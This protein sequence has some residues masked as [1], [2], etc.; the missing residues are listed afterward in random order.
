MSFETEQPFP[1]PSAGST[2]HK[3]RQP[4][5]DYKIGKSDDLTEELAS[6]GSLKHPAVNPSELMASERSATNS[7][8]GKLRPSRK[9]PATNRTESRTA[10]PKKHKAK[11][12]TVA[13]YYWVTSGKGWALKGSKRD[14]NGN[15]PYLGYLSAE[16]YHEMKSQFKGD[17]LKAVLRQWIEE[18]VAAKNSN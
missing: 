9:R 11:P 5:A 3:N 16:R 8:N 1:A 17:D 12:L 15:N 4:I 14:A 18:T 6:M 2:A 7:R 10:T 13:G